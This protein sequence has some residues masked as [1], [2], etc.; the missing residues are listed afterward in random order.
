MIP[1][2]S[3]VG[4]GPIGPANGDIRVASSAVEH[5]AFNR[6][7]L[8]S[9]LRRPMGNVQSLPSATRRCDK[10]EFDLQSM[11]M[12][13]S[14]QGTPNKVHRPRMARS[15]AGIGLVVRPRVLPPVHQ[16]F[17]AQQ[18]R[19]LKRRQMLRE[20]VATAVITF[21]LTSVAVAMPT[22][23]QQ[24]PMATLGTMKELIL[25]PAAQN[26]QGALVDCP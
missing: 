19:F 6:L 11:L 17:E 26:N 5:S 13:P 9:N 7:V 1:S 12:T 16:C 25:H 24:S 22:T 4:S 2:L 10:K 20:A 3:P 8:S 18:Q 21:L 23:F 15:N 14:V